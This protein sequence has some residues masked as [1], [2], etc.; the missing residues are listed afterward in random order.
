[1]PDCRWGRHNVLAEPRHGD[2]LHQAGILYAPDYFINAGGLIHEEE[3]WLSHG[4]DHARRR[5]LGV[6]AMVAQVL[7]RA[8]DE[9]I[10][11]HHA[12]GL[13]VRERIAQAR[14]EGASMYLPR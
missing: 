1:M 8:K 11:T 10:P 7:A 14:R 9:G 2:A 6:G 3:Q 5:V 13:I 12:A 4:R